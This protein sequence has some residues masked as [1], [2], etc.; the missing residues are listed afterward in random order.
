MQ[1]PIRRVAATLVTLLAATTMA[2]PAEAATD[3]S[4]TSSAELARAHTGSAGGPQAD[5]GSASAARVAASQRFAADSGDECRYGYTE[6]ELVW[7]T[8][9]P[10]SQVWIT[11]I[12]ADRPL[13]ADPGGFCRDDLRYSSASFTA[14]AGEVQVARVEQRVNNGTQQLDLVLDAG[15]APRPVDL[16]I[17]QVCRVSLLAP[18]PQPEYCG[19]PQKYVPGLSIES[20]SADHGASGGS[21]M[22]TIPSR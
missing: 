1:R 9:P 2:S 21:G 14:Y 18:N 6:G 15:T 5:S 11:G 4:G 13:P 16:V 19:L 10:S 8:A 20:G 3:P 17:V 12:V 22:V 7:I